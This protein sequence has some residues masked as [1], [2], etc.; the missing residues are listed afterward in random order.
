MQNEKLGLTKEVLATKALPFLFPL[1]IENGLTLSQYNVV[2][3]LIKQ[4]VSKVEEE[5]KIKL[6]QLNSIKDEQRYRLM[7]INFT[8]MILKCFLLLSIQI[9]TSNMHVRQCTTEVK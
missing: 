1:S 2:M 7:N 3:N 6:E 9:G 8:N 5:H 4:M